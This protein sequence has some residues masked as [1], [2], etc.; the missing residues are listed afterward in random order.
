MRTS[1]EREVG[2]PVQ[3]FLVLLGH[4]PRAFCSAGLAVISTVETQRSFLRIQNG[5]LWAPFPLCIEFSLLG[6]LMSVSPWTTFNSIPLL[7]NQT[8]LLGLEY[9]LFDYIYPDPSCFGI[10]LISRRAL[11]YFLWPRFCPGNIPID[12]EV[13]ITHMMISE[14]CKE[15]CPNSRASETQ[16]VK[17]SLLTAV[18]LYFSGHHTSSGQ[19]LIQSLFAQW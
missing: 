7:K 2:K 5:C 15:A 12:A 17:S 1:R 10:L 4:K 18:I 6:R 11:R 13:C 16:P 19:F 8:N 14:N 9:F 3:Q